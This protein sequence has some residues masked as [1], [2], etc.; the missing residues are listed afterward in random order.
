MKK[1]IILTGL[2]GFL[3]FSQL[4]LAAGIAPVQANTTGFGTTPLTEWEETT[5]TP[6]GDQLP[7]NLTAV[8]NPGVLGGMS[9]EQRAFLSKNGFVVMHTGEEQFSD[10]RH[11]VA[12]KNGQPYFL[13]TDAAY[14]ALHIN[15]DALLKQLEKECIEWRSSRDHT[16]CL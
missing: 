9:K 12:D 6:Q 10:I 8:E 4:F 13:T 5:Y 14:H 16:G 7:V 1:R 11:Q 2:S 15:F 3:I